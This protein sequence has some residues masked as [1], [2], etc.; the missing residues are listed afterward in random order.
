VAVRFLRSRPSLRR[1]RRRE[2]GSGS[3]AVSA[4]PPDGTGDA[5]D[6]AEAVWEVERRIS[7]AMSYSPFNPVRSRTGRDPPAPKLPGFRDQLAK[8]H[9]NVVCGVAVDQWKA[10][11]VDEWSPLI[12]VTAVW[13]HGLASGVS[14]QL[15][16]RR[17]SSGWRNSRQNGADWLVGIE[18]ASIQLDFSKWTSRSYSER[19][20][21][22]S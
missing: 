4:G 14:R 19:M 17:A 6:S 18:E 2:V 22:W 1:E 15:D 3:E 12:Q 21:H 11:H 16:R 8:R 20:P 13:M 9:V 7:S 10:S 5:A